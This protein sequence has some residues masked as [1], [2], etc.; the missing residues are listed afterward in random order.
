MEVLNLKFHKVNIPFCQKRSKFHIGKKKTFD[1]KSELLTE[2]L[3][4]DRTIPKPFILRSPNI[5]NDNWV[6]PGWKEFRKQDGPE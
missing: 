3:T 4:T 1:W 6:V 2:N 5:D